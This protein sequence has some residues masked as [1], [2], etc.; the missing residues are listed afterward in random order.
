MQK[1]LAELKK[2]LMEIYDLQHAGA[3]L[4][5]DEA[6]YMPPGGAAARGRQSALIARLMQ[7]KSIE[8]ALG[9]LLDELRPY[10]ESL[11]YDSYD[12]SLIRVARREYERAIKL[13]PQFVAEFFEHIS[14]SYNTWV[15]A[16]PENN[17]KALEPLL[18][19]TLDLSRRMAD[20]YPGYEHIADPL[21]D[22]NDYGMKATTLPRT[23]RPVTT[24]A[25]AHRANHHFPASCR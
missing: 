25:G 1:Q 9:K 24:G 14:K 16:R 15:T 10:E 7:E 19:R 21:I 23:V 2:R 22:Y 17:F 4:T 3:L 13:P 5:W 8:P 12:A 18:E 11:P 20:F 6:T